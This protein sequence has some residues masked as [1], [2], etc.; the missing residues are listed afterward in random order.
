MR[1]GASEDRPR[2]E[3]SP[4]RPHDNQREKQDKE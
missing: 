3:E 4:S 2:R 1:E